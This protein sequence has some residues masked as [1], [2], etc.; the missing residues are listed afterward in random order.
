MGTPE[1]AVP[2]LRALAACSDV[3][4]VYSRPDSVSGRGGHTRPSPVSAAA[5]ELGLVVRQPKTLR[6]APVLGELE[7]LHADLLVVAAYGLILPK[8][9]LDAASLGAVN[10]HA[11]LLPRWRG[12]APIQ[13]AILAG[14][15]TTGVS[16]MRMEEGL[17]TGPYCLQ[18]T[19]D[20]AGLSAAQ[21]TD[22][23]AH[24][25]AKALIEALPGIQSARAVWVVQDESLV[26]YADK[27]AKSDVALDPSLSAQD[28]ARRVR[29]SMPAAP[30]RIS[31]GG[32]GATVVEASV[33]AESL[34]PGALATTK[35]ALLLGMS[36]G[37]LEVR[38]I[39]P[40][41]KAEMEACAWARGVRDLSGTTW[42]ATT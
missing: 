14:D 24:L 42:G 7:A 5:A 2:S 25:G 3:V 31:I 19:L 27:V 40:D 13:R 26:T 15:S 39:K 11:S 30:S 36:D 21:A 34:A 29:A 38:R 20:L 22:A 41:G 28:A 4:A 35:S 32:R 1:F 23:L 6:H 37:A 33:S 18:A 8:Q 17:D 16:I 12:A 9:A 10:V